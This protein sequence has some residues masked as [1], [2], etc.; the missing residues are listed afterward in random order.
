M[1][2]KLTSF[3]LVLL[4]LLCAVTVQAG[5]AAGYRSRVTI[6]SEE[7]GDPTDTP[8]PSPTDTATPSPTPDDTPTPTPTQAT[9]TPTAGPTDT[10]LRITTDEKLPTGRVGHDYQVQIRANYGDATFQIYN[11]PSGSN[12]FPATGLTLSAEGL[13]SGRPIAAGTFKFYIQA[14]SD[15]ANSDCHKLFVLVIE[16]IPAT[17][18]PTA[19]PATPTPTANPGYTPT[20]GPTGAVVT[21]EPTITPEPSPTCSY[22]AF[23]L[24][25]RAADTVQRVAI[26]SQ[27]DIPL[28]DGI[29][30]YL[31][32]SDLYGNLPA[33]VE[34][35]NDIAT[36]RSCSVKGVLTG[37]NSYEFAVEFNI[38]GGRKL[39]LNFRLIADEETAEQGPVFPTGNY[40]VPFGGTKTAAILPDNS[41][42]REEDA[43]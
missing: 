20:P 11:N 15:S 33:S 23:P 7:P 34:F 19:Q 27:F 37:A 4:M 16:N 29:S 10:P 13:I 24:W 41:R 3:M 6:L 42:R 21:P 31:T 38:R 18:T 32:F 14:H 28:I 12:D 1:I 22:I 26:N 43:V 8:E 35:V 9:P 30:D 36:N 5:G 17:A 2:K 25:Q 40:L 39:M